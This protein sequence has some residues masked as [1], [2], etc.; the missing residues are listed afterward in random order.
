MTVLAQVK[1]LVETADFDEVIFPAKNNAGASAV[2]MGGVDK[3]FERVN[4]FVRESA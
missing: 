2:Q 4:E 1:A 3:I